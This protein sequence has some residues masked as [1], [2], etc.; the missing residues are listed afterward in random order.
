VRY[1][2]PMTKL[3]AAFSLGICFSLSITA[4]A[5]SKEADRIKNAAAVMHEIMATPD[6]GIP[7]SILEHAACVAVVPAFKKGAFIVGAEGGKGIVSCRKENGSW[8]PP[9]MLTVGGASFGFQAGGQST[10]VVMVIRNRKGIDFL[11]KDKFEVGGDLSAAAGPVGR[12]ATAGTDALA[13]AEIYTYS[14]SRGLFAGISLKGAVVKPDN[15]G[16]KA[17]YGKSVDAAALLKEGNMASPA[18]AEPFLTEL[19]KYSPKK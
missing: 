4:A 7:H 13:S 19:R 17:I 8:G 15:D 14:R 18:V 16:N 3:T 1:N 6:K 11:T 5:A 12:D 2:A 9:S 10:D